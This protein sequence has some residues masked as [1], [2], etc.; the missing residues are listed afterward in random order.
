M[1][2]HF[3]YLFTIILFVSCSTD[4]TDNMNDEDLNL[5]I[6]KS[7]YIKNLDDEEKLITY[8]LLNNKEKYQLWQE[9]YQEITNSDMFQKFNLDQVNFI[10]EMYSSLSPIHFQENAKIVTT[11]LHSFQKRGK[12]V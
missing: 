4:G 2:K 3:I 9:R 8:K 6:E 7:N 11:L 5:T 10:K 1:M 12:L